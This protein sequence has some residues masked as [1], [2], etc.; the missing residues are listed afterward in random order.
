MQTARTYSNVTRKV[1]DWRSAVGSHGIKNIPTG[2]KN[3][4]TGIKN[5]PTVN[6]TGVQYKLQKRMSERAHSLFYVPLG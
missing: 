6:L 3:I 4:P 1:P 5:I 2:I